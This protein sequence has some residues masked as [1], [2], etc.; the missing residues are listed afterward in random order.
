MPEVDAITPEAMDN[1][2]GAE[3]MISHGDTVT[4]GSVRRR[5]SNVEVIAI[6]IDNGN[7]ILDIQTYEVDFEDVSMSTYSANVIAKIMYAQR[8]EEGQQYLL[9][10]SILDHNTDGYA[11]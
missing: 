2:I 7:T 4:Q 5:K 11:L 6:V 9:F 8:D 3:I 10:E 1:Y